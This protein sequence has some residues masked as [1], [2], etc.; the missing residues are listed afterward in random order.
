MS[1]HPETAVAV[2]S[3]QFMQLIERCLTEKLDVSVIER[4][5]ALRNQERLLARRQVY[6]QSIK[7]VQQTIKGDIRKSG[8]NSVFQNP[9]AKLED[10]EAAADPIMHA[11]GLSYHYGSHFSDGYGA[12]VP[13]CP[14]KWQRCVIIVSH[15]NGFTEEHHMDGPP[16]IGTGGR[17]RTPIQSVGS[18]NT[19]LRKYLLQNVLNLVPY[20]DPTDNDGNDDGEVINDEQIKRIAELLR[21]TKYDPEEFLS[22]MFSDIARVEDIPARDFHRCLAALNQR[23]QRMAQ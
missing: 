11:E 10:L 6:N 22:L 16:D 18:T 3:D 14:E 8:F 1:D 15:D 19:Y 12:G 20:A 5:V 17:A 2:A 9:Y 23:K 21:E 7:R 13:P 4:L